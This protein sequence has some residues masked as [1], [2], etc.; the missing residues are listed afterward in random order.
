M[1]GGNIFGAVVSSEY[2]VGSDPIVYGLIGGSISIV[3]MF[4]PQL[5]PA[6][7]LCQK[8]CAVLMLIVVGVIATFILMGQ[9]AI[10]SK[11]MRQ[12]QI[13]HPD[14]FGSVGGLIYG[15][16]SMW[17]LSGVA[18]KRN[19]RCAVR[20]TVLFS[21]GLGLIALLTV[22]LFPLLFTPQPETDKHWYIHK[23]PEAEEPSDS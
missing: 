8:I 15:F 16:F 17:Y 2:S 14:V 11:W 7:A 13:W 19:N 9:A 6:E 4:W 12:N 1:L 10:S 18:L 22:I 23:E 5:G 21:V 20:E 3:V